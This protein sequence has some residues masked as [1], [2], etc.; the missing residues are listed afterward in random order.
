M[1]Y[2]IKKWFKNF[3]RKIKPLYVIQKLNSFGLWETYVSSF[4]I[5]PISDIFLELKARKKHS[6]YILLKNNQIINVI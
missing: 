6:T 2:L 4:D 5:E 3:K 1:A